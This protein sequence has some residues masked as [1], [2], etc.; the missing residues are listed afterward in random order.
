MRDWMSLHS[1]GP[2]RRSRRTGIALCLAGALTLS[3]GPLSMAHAADRAFAC[4]NDKGLREY[5]TVDTARRRITTD[6]PKST[7]RTAF[8]DGT[9]ADP[10]SSRPGGFCVMTLGGPT[11]A[12]QFVRV[13]GNVVTYG[14]SNENATVTETFDMASGLLRLEDGEIVAECHAAHS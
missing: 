2:A 8:Q 14:A 3:A 9:F 7:C 5:V 1:K 6:E 13:Q 10:I 12:H 4:T 11:P